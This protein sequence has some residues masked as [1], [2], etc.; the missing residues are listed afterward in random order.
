MVGKVTGKARDMSAWSSNFATAP[1]ETIVLV[2]HPEW[3]CPALLKLTFEFSPATGDWVFC[4][5]VL[6]DIDGGLIST[7]GCE[8]A[9]LPE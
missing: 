4:E 8:W 7:A 1:S 9:L 6:Q 3:G 2:R 5:S